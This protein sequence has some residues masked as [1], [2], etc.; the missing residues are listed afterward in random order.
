MDILLKQQMNRCKMGI[1]YL[2][3]ALGLPGSS[4][5]F[6]QSTVESNLSFTLNAAGGYGNIKSEMFDYSIGELVLTETY[7][8]AVPYLLTQGFLQPFYMLYLKATDVY[9]INNILTP[10]SD[11]ENDV[12]LVKGLDSYPGSKLTVFD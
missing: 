10:N 3:F 7:A 11:G 6:A 1:A 8:G 5:L 12:F 2:F 4:G 9:A